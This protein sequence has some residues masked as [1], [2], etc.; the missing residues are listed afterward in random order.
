[1]KSIGAVLALVTMASA[2]VF[3][4]ALLIVVGH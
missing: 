3:I 1:L 4:A 2:L